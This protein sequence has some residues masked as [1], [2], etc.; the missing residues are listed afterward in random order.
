MRIAGGACSARKRPWC[1]CVRQ[2]A[3]TPCCGYQM[4]IFQ[5]GHPKNYLFLRWQYPK[6][7]MFNLNLKSIH[8]VRYFNA[9]TGMCVLRVERAA[10]AN[11]L[12]AAASVSLLLHR[13]VAIRCLALSGSIRTILSK[14][15]SENSDRTALLLKTLG[16]KVRPL[17][18][19]GVVIL[20]DISARSPRQLRISI[21]QKQYV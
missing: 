13:V 18:L 8:A 4:H 2:P 12:D 9:I 21:I 10:H 16:S 1:S 3:T 7:C 11:V 14:A 5:L 20:A 17:L 19:P 15:V 6:E